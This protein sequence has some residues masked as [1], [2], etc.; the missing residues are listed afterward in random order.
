MLYLILFLNA[1]IPVLKLPESWGPIKKDIARET[2]SSG[3]LEAAQ[4]NHFRGES[5]KIAP[6]GPLVG[7]HPLA[8]LFDLSPSDLSAKYFFLTQYNV[9]RV[10]CGKPDGKPLSLAVDGWKEFLK[11][12]L[13]I[14]LNICTQIPRVL[15]PDR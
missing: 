10:K 14:S 15:G 13:R 5:I 8:H 11:L 9:G 7:D 4:G 3:Q 2:L 6:T 1:L 12:H